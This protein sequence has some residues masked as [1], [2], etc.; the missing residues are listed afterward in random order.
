MQA[1]NSFCNKKKMKWKNKK[2]EWEA[3]GVFLSIC[4][5]DGLYASMSV[6]VYIYFDNGLCRKKG[7]WKK[8]R[9]GGITEKI[10]KM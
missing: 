6:R 1:E 9:D 5:Y 4:L 7:M 10:N 3:K 2:K 8:I